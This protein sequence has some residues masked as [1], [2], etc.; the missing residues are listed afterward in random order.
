MIIIQFSHCSFPNCCVTRQS[1]V[2]P[3]PSLQALAWSI[4]I[5]RVARDNVWGGS[6]HALPALLFLL[7][8]K[9]WIEILPVRFHDFRLA[10]PLPSEG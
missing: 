5:D 1:Q 4:S 3:D 6:P 2:L 8:A 9:F 7:K 10:R